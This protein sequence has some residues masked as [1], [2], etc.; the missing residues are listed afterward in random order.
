MLRTQD[1]WPLRV[2]TAP[3]PGLPEGET[4]TSCRTSRLSSDAERRSYGCV[5]TYICC[6]GSTEMLLTCESADQARERTVMAC[7]V[8]VV[9][10]IFVARSK[11]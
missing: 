4:R 6:C 10:S 9:D 1:E 3:E 11:M 2:A 8:Y 5:S 7:D